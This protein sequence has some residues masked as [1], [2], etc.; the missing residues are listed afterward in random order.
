MNARGITVRR[1]LAGLAI[2]AMTSGLALVI[3]SPAQAD[4]G[5]P[6]Y[7]FANSVSAS[8]TDSA[9]PTKAFGTKAGPYWIGSW[10][11]SNG[12]SHESKAYFTFDLSSYKGA[13]IEDARFIMTENSVNDCDVP[14]QTAL[15]QTA[16]PTGKITW[17]DAPAESKKIF[18]GKNTVPGCPAS[19]LAFDAKSIVAQD[20]T[21]TGIVTVEVSVPA[22]YA[23]NPDYGRSLSSLGLSLTYDR[24]PDAP[25]NMT[26]NGVTCGTKQILINSLAPIVHA[27]LTDPDESNGSGNGNGPMSATIEVWPSA[28]P[29]L[30]AMYTDVVGTDAPAYL[31]GNIPAGELVDGGT[32]VMKMQASDGILT[33]K[34]SVPCRFGVDTTGPANPPTVTSSDYPEGYDAP[35]NGGTN[36]PG[37]FTFSAN[38]DKSVIGFWYGEYDE[39]EYVAA[40]KPGGTATVTITPT[41]P[42]PYPLIVAGTDKAQNH[43]PIN[44]YDFLVKDNSP[45]VADAN[46]DGKFREARSLT[47]TPNQSGTIAYYVYDVNNEGE[48]TVT[49]NAD[50]TAQVSVTPDQADSQNTLMVSSVNTDGYESGQAQYAMFFTTNPIVTSVQYPEGPWSGG[51]GVKGTFTFAPAYAGI[52]SYTYSFDGAVAQTV[53]A[54]ANGKATV[55]W[56]PT[57]S[58][59]H[60][61]VVSSTDNTG[62]ISDQTYYAIGV[63]SN[64]PTITSDVYQ[65]YQQAGG[66]GVPGT[67][68]FTSHQTGATSF[69][70]QFGAEAAQTV[71]VGTDG[72]ASVTW[73]PTTGGTTQLNV[74]TTNAA[75][76]QSDPTSFG[77]VV[78]PQAPT[79]AAS[80]TNGDYTFTVTSNLPGSTSFVWSLDSGDPHTIPV[81]SDGTATFSATFDAGTVHDLSVYTKAGNLSSATTDYGF[82]VSD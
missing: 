70:Y 9:S 69:V 31:W 23:S 27:N 14:R 54:N 82:Y 75:G 52:V 20:V 80:D 81:G 60:E 46:P 33:G 77:V 39:Q 4:G 26:I 2:A 32:Y 6:V 12:V 7:A 47:F 37:A 41:Y 58:G 63:N 29:S 38:G 1:V 34:W 53:A 11:D 68:T 21:G 64:Q 72:T 13:Q 30:V 28:D 59:S 16:T 57:T 49:A 43:S 19:Y 10:Q 15:W 76:T 24:A 61:L 44:E 36:V 56:T 35:P 48:Q 79:V 73:A 22:A 50:G 62:L 18:S 40:D 25:T 65:N 74:Y 51:V 67:F 5:I 17:D 42:G 78:D 55:H 3:A 45:T 66:L 71:P 8:Y